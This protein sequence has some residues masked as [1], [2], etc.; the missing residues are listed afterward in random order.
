[1]PRFYSAECEAMT[2]ISEKKKCAEMEMLKFIYSN[3]KYPAA[4]REAGIQGKVIIQFIIEKDG[5]VSEIKTLRDIGG[6]AAEEAVRVMESSPKWVPGKQRGKNVRVQYTLPVSFKLEGDS[7]NKEKTT[8]ENPLIVI[9]GVVQEK[10]DL[11]KLGEASLNPDEIATVSVIKGDAAIKK[12]GDAGK[13]GV[14]EIIT[15]KAIAKKQYS[16]NTYTGEKTKYYINGKRTT[17]A[18]FKSIPKD[19]I[20]EIKKDGWE[21]NENGKVMEMITSMDAIT[22][23]NSNLKLE[24]V[25]VGDGSADTQ[26]VWKEQTPQEAGFTYIKISPNPTDGKI[27]IEYGSKDEK[28]TITGTDILGQEIFNYNLEG[29][30]NS[31]NDIDISKAA[32]G[33]VLVTF[34]QGKNVY[35]E[36]VILQ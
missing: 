25:P 9:D 30:K 10:L 11:N 2:D 33:I 27:N 12:Y 16:N 13:N 22:K 29:G 19:E 5:S 7:P 31:L 14:V 28:L 34:R 23:S 26:V 1:M 24:E 36:K 4:A 3:I 8:K 6:G 32:K 35:T 15:K 20:I 21:V 17:E 18:N